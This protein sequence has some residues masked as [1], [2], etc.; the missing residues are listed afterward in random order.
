MA[1]A[2]PGAIQLQPVTRPYAAVNVIP[3]RL[4]VSPA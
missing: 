3:V 2:S 4:A 1:T